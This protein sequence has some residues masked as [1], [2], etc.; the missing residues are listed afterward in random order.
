[1]KFKSIELNYGNVTGNAKE[2]YKQT[3]MKMCVELSLY[4]RKRMELIDQNSGHLATSCS[5][6]RKCKAQKSELRGRLN[7]LK[8]KISFCAHVCAHTHRVF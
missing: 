6:R 4:R 2:R 3:Y 1:M 5:Q 7:S 8:D